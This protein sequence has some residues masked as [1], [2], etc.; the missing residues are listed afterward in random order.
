MVTEC[1]Y[2]RKK[3]VRRE[4][5]TPGG[6][7]RVIQSRLPVSKKRGE[8]KKPQPAR[9][10]QEGKKGELHLPQNEPPTFLSPSCDFSLSFRSLCYAHILNLPL[11]LRFPLCFSPFLIL[12]SSS[13][14]LTHVFQGL[15]SIDT[16]STNSSSPAESTGAGGGVWGVIRVR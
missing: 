16:V 10:K 8:G 12:L 13:V 11:S 5:D 2:G 6:F 9:Q 4:G 3:G 1:I 7:T 14:T 15:P